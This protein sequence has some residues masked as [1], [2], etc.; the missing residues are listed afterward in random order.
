MPHMDCTIIGGPRDGGSI[1]LALNDDIIVFV[2]RGDGIIENYALRIPG[3]ARLHFLNAERKKAE[4]ITAT[5]PCVPP[6]AL[7]GGLDP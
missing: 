7:K 6:P 2:E 3:D 1:Q 5:G 4:R